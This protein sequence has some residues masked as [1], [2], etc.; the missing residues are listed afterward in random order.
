MDFLSLFLQ[1]LFWQALGELIRPKPKYQ[2]NKGGSLKDLSFPTADPSRPV[3]K[4]FGRRLID[5]ANLFGTWDYKVEERYKKVKTGFFTSTKQPLPPVYY[6]SAG[7]VLCLDGG[8]R[9]K[10]VWVGDRL[11]WEGDAGTGSTIP[12]DVEYAEQGYE[13]SPKGIKGVL[14][15]HS[16]DSTPSAYIA[17][18][19]PAGTTPAWPH[20][21]YVVLRGADG[22]SGAWI[23]TSQQ[24]D[25]LKI[26]CERYPTSA[27][28][29]LGS[30]TGGGKV[31][32]DANPAYVIAETLVDTVGGAGLPSTMQDAA[33]F[34][35]VAAKLI[36]EKHGTSQLWDNQRTS[37]D[38]VAE[39]CRQIGG[40]LVQDPATGKHRLRLFRAADPIALTLD[41]NNVKEVQSFARA[42]MSE[43]TNALALNYTDRNSKNYEQK[44]V[45]VQDTAAVDA[46][47]AVISGTTSYAGI[48]DAATALNV[49]LRDLRAL[50]APLATARVVAIVPKSS[51]LVV[52]DPVAFSFAPL[53]IGSLRMRV[54]RARYAQQG[55]ALCEVELVEDVF[56]PG[57]ALYGTTDP[58]DPSD[59][60]YGS[61]PGTP[62]INWGVPPVVTPTP[63]PVLPPLPAPPNGGSVLAPAALSG[64]AFSDHQLNYSYPNGVAT[65]WLTQHT[66][67]A[68]TPAE[69][70][71]G[72]TTLLEFSA[73]VTFSPGMVLPDFSGGTF[74]ATPYDANHAAFLRAHLG[75]IC[76]A[77]AGPQSAP[78]EW[79]RVSINTVSEDGSSCTGT[80]HSRGLFH[81]IAKRRTVT[82]LELIYAADVSRALGT[83]YTAGLAVDYA[84][85]RGRNLAGLSSVVAMHSSA[86]ETGLISVPMPPGNIRLQ[87]VANTNAPVAGLGVRGGSVRNPDGI[88]IPDKPPVTT[89]EDST[90]LALTF[91]PRSRQSFND[92]PWTTGYGYDSDV[93][94]YLYWFWITSTGTAAG[95]S[96]TLPP[97]TT[98]THIPIN[99]THWSYAS[100]ASGLG[101][102]IE[103]RRRVGGVV[104][105]GE[106]QTWYWRK[107]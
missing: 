88:D 3:Q 86:G 29:G 76:Y 60:A 70:S 35:A 99:A 6:V 11:A 81:T 69:D 52:G 54:V 71:W 37:G 25:H 49:G 100:Y 34:H 96:I 66:E 79:F 39:I 83:N 36:S 44:P 50:S 73:S 84:F 38:V 103:P 1:F 64:D 10:R 31:G 57:G 7:M 58:T 53:G 102:Y 89:P 59:P 105:Q 68:D 106:P 91:N 93:E 90:H 67:T 75:V 61:E 23:G 63:T 40:A 46:A 85:K 21:S 24:V 5:N 9:I 32:V 26:E 101:V 22:A 56:Q 98:H 77:F 13:D 80:V 82:G 51:R 87:A 42:S 30:L 45:E 65:A 78:V 97:G 27:S 104:L 4:L 43:A 95:G 72:F 33:S 92:Q 47:G 62:P 15:F 55:Q 41:V 94:H 17:S 74:T 28:T 48:M 8:V 107:A 18:K 16:G 14:E 19:M 2:A 20:L 12:L